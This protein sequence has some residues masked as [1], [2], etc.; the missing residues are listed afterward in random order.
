MYPYL[1]P[2]VFGYN[3]PMYDIMI[4][5][6]LFVMLA[7]VARRLEKQDGYT[8]KQTNKLLLFLVLSL[9]IT[10]LSSYIVD[11]VFHF[12]GNYRE[13]ADAGMT[14][15]EIV[16]GSFGSVTFIGGLIGG[17]A[18]LILFIKYGYKESNKDLRKILNT[19]I[20]GVV[21]AHAIGRIGCF[22]AG[23]CYGIPTESFLG[24]TFPHGHSEGISVYPTQLFESIF[25]FILFILLNKVKSFKNMETEV[26]LIGYGAFRVLN[27]FFRGDDR[28]SIFGFITTQYNTYPSPSQ[29]LSLIMVG[30]GVYLLLKRKKANQ[31]KKSE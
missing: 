2:D 7:Y 23:C 14:F 31:L 9:G 17:L 13:M 26:Y 15:V 27:E 16:K 4:M 10:L 22:F 5:L 8:R 12:I 18:A 11:G 25:L 30:F 1:L 19:I 21:I 6:G 28:G 20:T 3:L 29:Y 24:V